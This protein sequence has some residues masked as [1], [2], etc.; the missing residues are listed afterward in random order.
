MPTL[1]VV[2]PTFGKPPSP[3]GFAVQDAIVGEL[4]ADSLGAYTGCG[5]TEGFSVFGYRVADETAAR[6]A[7]ARAME[8]H[9]PGTPY[10]VRIAGDLGCNIAFE[11]LKE[12]TPK[13]LTLHRGDGQPLGTFEQVQAMIRDLFARAEL[14]GRLGGPERVPIPK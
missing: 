13:K 11:V 1:F 5:G 4:D 10:H 9:L 8:K 12:F 3:Y 7:L 14:V 6:D 2:V